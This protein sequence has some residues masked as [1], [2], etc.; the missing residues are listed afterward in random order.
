MSKSKL[1]IIIMLIVASVGVRLI[2]HFWNIIPAFNFTPVLAMAIF[3]G[4]VLDNKKLA[5]LIPLSAMVVSDFFIGFYSTVWA[6]YLILAAIVGI[7]FLLHNRRTPLRI[8]NAS[9]GGSILFFILSNFGVWV[10]G[11]MYPMTFSG[12]TTCYVAAIPFFH[13]T[14]FSTLFFSAAIFGAYHLC[15][16][17]WIVEK[18]PV[19]NRL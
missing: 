13:N 17:K 16:K 2:T 4:A 12:L 11:T 8:F 3:A 7:G 15:E 5:I 19:A 10:F 14:L 18:T 1:G 9:V 6:T